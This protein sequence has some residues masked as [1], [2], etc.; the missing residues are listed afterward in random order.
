M[1]K[2]P[3]LLPCYQL[4]YVQLQWIE[5]KAVSCDVDED[6]WRNRC[7]SRARASVRTARVSCLVRQGRVP[8][9]GGFIP[10]PT[11]TPPGVELGVAAARTDWPALCTSA[12]SVF[13]PVKLC[14]PVMTPAVAPCSCQRC[15]DELTVRVSSGWTRLLGPDRLSC[16]GHAMARPHEST[17]HCGD[18]SRPATTCAFSN[19][20]YHCFTKHGPQEE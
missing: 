7:S 4:M 14:P 6:Q 20:A 10:P 9:R 15:S 8:R 12:G 3:Q 11:A 2:V 17:G 16:L 19:K 13:V 18:D 5:L 1:G